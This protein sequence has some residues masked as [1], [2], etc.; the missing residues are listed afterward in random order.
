MD[1]LDVFQ[2]LAVALAIGLLI[3][4]ERGWHE[5]AE[6]EGERT[7]GLRTHALLGLLGGIWGALVRDGGP[8]GL[9]ALA[10]AFLVVAAVIAVFRL[11]EITK[12]GTFGATTLVA[13]MLA[14]VLGAYA[15]QGSMPAAAAAGVAVAGLLALKGA[16][17]GW[18]KR[19]TWPELR[20]T[21]LLLAMSVILLPILPDRGMGP[22][23]AFNPRQLWLLTILLAAVSFAGYIAVKVAGERRGIVMTGIAGGLVYSTAVTMTLA[24]LARDHPVQSRLCLAGMVLASGVM[25]LRVLTVVGVLKSD[26]LT[27]IWAPLAAGGAVLWIAGAFFVGREPADNG[28]RPALKLVNPFDLK[29][30]LIWGAA[31]AVITILSKAA[32]YWLGGQGLL[33]AAGAVGIIDVD[34]IT[35]SMTGLAGGD[36]G[37]H[38]AAAAILVAV[39]VNTVT[40]AVYA[41]IGG[42]RPI[43]MRYLLIAALALLAGI[44][45]LL[46][47]VRLTGPIV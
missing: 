10:I 25:V 30:V 12:E 22:F 31:I 37:V 8:G 13:G 23:E 24:K 5:R 33:A 43:G 17:H 15:V 47:E 41:W 4:I 19:L 42:G 18:L 39:A 40:K 44:L 6:G 16:L 38:W 20:A 3:G 36:L 26:L 34:A 27:A 7:A 14:F 29:E 21:L 45:G 32:A 28:A 35:L 11:R 1:T 9:I 46:A 2:R